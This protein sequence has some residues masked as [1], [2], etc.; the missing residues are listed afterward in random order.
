MSRARTLIVHPP[1][2]IARDFIDYPYFS[3]LGA[4][5]LAAVLDAPVVDAF[6][7]PGSTLSWRA[8]GRAHLGASVDEVLAAVRAKGTFD[9]VVV[10]YTPF[11]RP[12]HRC[13]V[14]GALLA[15]LDCERI[16]LADC[17]QSG[18]H[19]VEVP[20]ESVL[21]SYPEVAAYVKYEAELT[22]PRVVEERGRGVFRGESPRL[23]E[24]PLPAWDRI[25]LASYFRFHQ[26]VVANLGRA[27]W[28]FPIDGRTIPVVTSRGCPFS[29]A[30][31][32]SNPERLP[33]EPKKQRRPSPERLGE[34]LRA[35]KETTGATRL[36]VL[37]ELVNVNERH[38]DAFLASM[39][40][41]DLRFELP[42][43]MRADYLERRHLE[44][45]KGRVTTV[46]VSAESGS[47]R[48][49]SDVVG[50]QLDLRDIARVAEDAHAVGVEL[51]IHYMIGLPGETR[52]EINET[53]AFA[54]DLWDRFRAFPAVQFA[55]PLPGTKLAHE[56]ER[57][58]RA[59]PIVEDWGPVFQHGPRSEEERAGDV[60]LAVLREFKETLDRRLR[61]SSGPE[62]LIVNLTYA[63]NNRC[64]FCAVGT[65][66]QLH[67]HTESQHEHLREY[68]ARG[69]TMVDFDG[70]E[71]T[72]HPD[73][74]TTV[75]YARSIG[76]ERVNVTTNGRMAFYEGFAKKLVRS[77][78]TSL[79]FSVH[80]PDAQSHAQQVGV[81]EAFEQTTGGIRNCVAHAPP[82]VELGMNVTL[83]KSN[84]DKLEQLAQLAWDLGLRWI[85][86]QFLTP[87]GR[88]TRM[89]APDTQYAAD[90]TRGVI[91]RWR[92]RMKVQ[93]INLPFC[94]LPGL[95]A[96]LE[97][98]L[99]KLAR[100]MIF[101]NNE[102]VNLAQYLAER[103][104]R[105]PVC[106][107]CT[108]AVFCGGFYELDKVP[109]PPWLVSVDDLVKKK[110]ASIDAAE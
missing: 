10:A 57:R 32:S 26:R 102:D 79:L 99:L 65:R 28:A 103:R 90:V 37:D 46:S 3:D 63:C 78:L 33:G 5:Q 14:L 74:I 6:A 12:P 66:T 92:D 47:P 52:E 34:T 25:D 55:T 8:D 80:G 49:V 35:L 16:V 73:L 75:R 101:V 59:L 76:Y 9:T 20:G 97:G 21:A 18:Q 17:F 69:V 85:N 87:F 29:C 62:K 108:R 44:L 48:V 68:R 94:F 56:V 54:M 100:H 7:L 51:L 67:G 36:F 41:L 4:L 86:I 88:A 31:C 45:M 93:V 106:E 104:V 27:A 71:P 58:G 53:L 15:G 24:L 83:T 98:D 38:F 89:I 50:K 2:T 1:T 110:P 77:G 81:A 72:L 19:Y 109:E 96:H 22:V 91:E 11:H 70:G 30:H 95:E 107:G 39:R 105:K 61:A 23:D 60:S 40:E 64:T 43:G 84:T 13:D 42:N 82:G